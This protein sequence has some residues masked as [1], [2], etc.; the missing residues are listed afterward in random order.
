MHQ[1]N[2]QGR[3]YNAGMEKVKRTT[4]IST[5]IGR[6]CEHCGYGVGAMGEGDIA[7]S[8]NH[9][10]EKHGYHLLH[11][12]TETDR[13]DDGK[14]VYHSV[15]VLGHDDPPAVRPPAQVVMQIPEDMQAPR[16]GSAPQIIK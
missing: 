7:D 1:S 14:L 16:G 13:S 5:N 10:I 3:R 12:G 6:G 4:H 2:R 11:V 9:Y 15:A 8:I